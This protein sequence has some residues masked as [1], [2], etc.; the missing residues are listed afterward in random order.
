[1]AKKEMSSPISE[2]TQT[3]SKGAVPSK[4]E[5][6]DKPSVERRF[7]ESDEAKKLVAWIQE[8]HTKAKTARHQKQAQ[9]YMN[10]SYFYGQQ[11][12]EF[13]RKQMPDGYRNQ[14]M[15]PKKPYYQSRKTINRTRSFVRTEL[16]KFLSKPPQIV[17]VPSTGEDQDLRAAYAA[18]QAWQSISTAKKYRTHYARA[19]WWMIMTGNGFI[20]TWWDQTYV[21]P[22]TGDVGDIFFGNV[23]PFHLFVPDLREQDIE[24]QPFLINAFVKPVEW[25]KTFFGEALQGVDLKATSSSQGQILDGG[26]L[27][28]QQAGSNQLDSVVIYE[29]WIK[30][31]AT[32][33]LPEGG[34]VV[35]VDDRLISIT[36][37]WP[38]KH[39]MYPYTKFEH[40]PTATFY[41]DSPLIDTNQLQRDYNTIRSEISEAGK[42]MARPGLLAAEGS[43]VPSKITNEPGLIVL[44]RPG[45]PKPEPMTLSPLPQYYL[46]QQNVILEDWDTVSGQHDVSR[47]TAPPGV[48]AGTAISFLQEQDNQFLTPQFLSIESGTERVAQQSVGLFVQYVDL[49]RKIK[50]IGA[51]GAFD[52]MMLQGADLKNGTDIRV[53][54]GSAVGQSKAA[55]RAQIMDMFS[56]GLIDQPTALKMLEVGGVQKVMDV[57]KVA[58]RKA[59]RENIKMKMLDLAAIQ[60]NQMTYA[61]ETMQDPNALAQL[62]ADPALLQQNPA[63]AQQMMAQIGQSAPPIIQVDDFDVHSVHIDTHNSF[64]M[65]Q[66]YETLPDEVKAQF[67]AHVLQHQQML[68]QQIQQQQMQQAIA[69]S[70]QQEPSA[71]Q[72]GPG[73]TMSG[74]GAVPDTAPMMQGA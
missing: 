33:L 4:F 57:M 62:G 13:S 20:K 69:G 36:R 12:V 17:S 73:A 3:S 29:T 65:T 66:E 59:Q 67:A 27:N 53:E 49:P 48:K 64:R 55:Q 10:M 50:V 6:Q 19:A 16:S 23:T 35:T 9:W 58:E 25:C 14:L 74:N 42:R 18:E 68:S 2:S 28:L 11:W 5:A 47:G 30:P 61:L 40:I 41:A 22:Y 37:G 15:L 26:T 39:G 71:T 32:K 70:P 45:L 1:M 51:D 56:V 52:T 63:L 72:Q 38:Y 31:N 46:Q 7:R 43:I 8:Q 60:T 44:Y 34:V 21:D 54:E 24:D